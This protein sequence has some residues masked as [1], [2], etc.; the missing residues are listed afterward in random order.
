[1]RLFP[2]PV[3]LSIAIWIFIFVSTGWFAVYGSLI[4]FAGI[5]VYFIKES[6]LHKRSR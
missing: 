4:A 3:L 5:G 1:M 2:V 6:S